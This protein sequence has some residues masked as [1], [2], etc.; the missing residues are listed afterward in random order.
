MS[1]KELFVPMPELFPWSVSA[2]FFDGPVKPAHIGFDLL[3]Q[4]LVGRFAPGPI[5]AENYPSHCFP[6]YQATEND[7]YSVALTDSSIYVFVVRVRVRSEFSITFSTTRARGPV[8]SPGYFL[9][10]WTRVFQR[11]AR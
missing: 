1:H 6:F 3:L 8:S 4:V 7:F 10:N 9:S 5:E 11:H 2:G